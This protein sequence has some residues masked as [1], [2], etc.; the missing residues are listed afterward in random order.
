MRTC[1]CFILSVLVLGLAGCK[2]KSPAAD[3][4][5]AKE[6]A[7]T[8]PAEA[9]PPDTAAPT[10]QAEKAEQPGIGNVTTLPD[11]ADHA[12]KLA[13]VAAD[14]WLALVDAGKLD[15]SWAQAAVYYRNA[16]SKENH[17]QAL[18]GVRGPLGD[19]V[20]REARSHEY[21]TALPGAP[22]GQYVV[23]QYTTRF[24]NKNDAVETVT[25]ML[26]SDGTWKVSGY[27]IK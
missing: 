19:V 11:D 12:V 6:Q 13:M 10:T 3:E 15:E 1:E 27:Y 2:E 26:E 18:N 24:A 23:I 9:E 22:D 7:T 21:A 25:P 5:P 14:A 4:S 16:V 17:A 20:S 8:R